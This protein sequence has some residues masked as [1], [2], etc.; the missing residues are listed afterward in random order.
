MSIS[1]VESRD[2]KTF[3]GVS[4]HHRSEQFE[5]S[6]SYRIHFRIGMEQFEEGSCYCFIL[7]KL[8]MLE[9][10]TIGNTGLKG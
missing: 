2:H 1:R 4:R 3:G 7:E 10:T 9:G 5:Q 6:I 8:S